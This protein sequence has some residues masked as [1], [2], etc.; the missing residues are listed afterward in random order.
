MDEN[1]V[2]R[3]GAALAYDAPVTETGAV[4]GLQEAGKSGLLTGARVAG[5]IDVKDAAA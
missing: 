2:A 4:V 3:L 5:G 1:R